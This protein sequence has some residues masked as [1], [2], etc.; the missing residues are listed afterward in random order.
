MSDDLIAAVRSRVGDSTN[1]E[2]TDNDIKRFLNARSADLD[3][4]VKMIEDWYMHA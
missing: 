4:A 2:I 1:A 3:A